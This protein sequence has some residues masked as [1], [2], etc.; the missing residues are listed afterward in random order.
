MHLLSIQYERNINNNNKRKFI[1]PPS[2]TWSGSTGHFTIATAT[3][4][5][6][7]VHTHTHTHEHTHVHTYTHTPLTD[8]KDKNGCGKERQVRN[9][10]K[11]TWVSRAVVN[12]EKESERRTDRGR[13]F[14][15]DGPV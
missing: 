1:Q 14:K 10:F 5:H 9:N 4:T 11:K 15:T 8:H 13:L 12:D 2:S 7:S 6:L 3:L